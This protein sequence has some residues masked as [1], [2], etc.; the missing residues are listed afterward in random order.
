[1]S[2]NLNESVALLNNLLSLSRVTTST[3]NQAKLDA[4]VDVLAVSALEDLE[5]F[6]VRMEAE[7]A[8]AAQLATE[9]EAKIASNLIEQE[10]RD[11]QALIQEEEDQAEREERSRLGVS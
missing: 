11:A 4:L 3:V 1:M 2:Q 6:S 9:T 5:R 10:E 7:A 8:A